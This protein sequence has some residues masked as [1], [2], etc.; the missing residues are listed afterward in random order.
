[1]IFDKVYII[2]SGS[3]CIS[4]LKSLLKDNI[5]PEIIL[6]KEHT[7]SILSSFTSNNSIVT[8]KF[9]TPKSLKSF[10]EN[11]K[12]KS[13][14][15]SAN[16][17]YLFPESVINNEYLKIINFHNA[18]LPYHRGMNAPTWSIFEQDDFAG[19]TWHLVNKNIDDGD[20]IIQKKIKLTQEETAIALIRQLMT[21]AFVSF[22]E[23][24][25]D[26]LIWDLKTIKMP[27]A[28]NSQIH[29]SK[30]IPNDGILDLKWNT[31]KIS[32]F[33]RS[34]NWGVIKQFPNAKILIQDEFYEIC[35]YEIL[36][37]TMNKEF[38]DKENL[39]YYK[40]NIK[41]KVIPL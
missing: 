41:I 10:L 16:N 29:Y 33:L 8:H 24:R 40:E 7:I 4:L 13:L 21:L 31:T 30:D 27:V 18:I 11:I 26:L 14:I 19:I 38:F 9:E 35:S 28:N 22:E 23:I 1:M 5:V 25:N 36:T 17:I 20:I 6:Y 3:I 2:G 34:L 15:I 12:E 39:F 37:K 32:A